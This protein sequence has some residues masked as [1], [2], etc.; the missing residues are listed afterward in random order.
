[1][2]D[3]PIEEESRNAI[4]VIH[5]IH[6]IHLI[7]LILRATPWERE[8]AQD[9]CPQAMN[10][11]MASFINTHLSPPPPPPYPSPLTVINTRT[12]RKENLPQ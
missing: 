10:I 6:V 4:H 9:P 5:V 2:E 1:M 12:H 7:H 11:S 8:R 3:V